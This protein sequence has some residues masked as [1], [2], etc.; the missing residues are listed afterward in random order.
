[1]RGK[2]LAHFEPFLGLADSTVQD[3][4]LPIIFKACDFQCD[5]GQHNRDIDHIRTT[6]SVP[7]PFPSQRVG[8][9]TETIMIQV[10][11]RKTVRKLG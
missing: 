3:P 7:V 10:L 5:I 4:G 8:S 2:G 6:Q 11:L 1:M 9:G